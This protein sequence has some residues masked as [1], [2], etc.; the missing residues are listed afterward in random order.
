MAAY[1]ASQK[2]ATRLHAWEAT[3]ARTPEGQEHCV[4]YEYASRDSYDD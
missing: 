2:D 4:H 3:F 1:K